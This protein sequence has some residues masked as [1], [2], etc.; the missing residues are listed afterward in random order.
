MA[1]NFLKFRQLGTIVWNQYLS[2]LLRLKKIIV[3]PTNSI[4]SII[5][6]YIDCHFV[7][8]LIKENISS[9]DDG[10]LTAVI[11]LGIS[12]AAQINIQITNRKQIITLKMIQKEK[13]KP[14]QKTIR[15]VI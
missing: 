12:M 2:F 5:K 8:E 11:V 10:C 4:F 13:M 3:K 15:Y 6:L 9:L 7:F 1:R 14:K